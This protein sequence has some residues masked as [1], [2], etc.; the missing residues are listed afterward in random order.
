MRGAHAP[1][2]PTLGAP[3]APVAERD[4]AGGELLHHAGE[5]RG[6]HREDAATVAWLVLEHLTLYHLATRRDLADRHAAADAGDLS[7]LRPQ[8]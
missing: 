7:R 4:D 3:A 5:E 1:T 2:S 8:L 6:L